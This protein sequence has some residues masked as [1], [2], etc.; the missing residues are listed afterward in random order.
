M[1]G[2]KYLSW[3]KSFYKVHLHR[4]GSYFF[5]APYKINFDMTYLCNSRCTNCGIWKIC[6]RD[7]ASVRRELSAAEYDQIFTKTASSLYFVSFEGGEPF[8]RKDAGNIFHSCLSRCKNLISLLIATNGSLPLR[9]EKIAKEILK[10]NSTSSLYFSISLD[11]FEETHNRL[12]GISNG[13]QLAVETYDR[14]CRIGNKRLI[15]FFQYT[16]C[17]SNWKEALSFYEKMPKSTVFTLYHC[18]PFFC[19]EDSP[20]GLMEMEERDEFLSVLNRLAKV[21]RVQ[22]P[23]DFLK[24]IYLYSALSYVRTRKNPLPCYA[25]FASLSADPYGDIRPCAF[26]PHFFGNL[27][28]S[29][30]ALAPLLFSEEARGIKNRLKKETCPL[31]WMNCDALPSMLHVFPKAI[32]DY[33][34]GRIS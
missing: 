30:Y 7:P 23:L 8:L 6:R 14:L 10:I 27:R 15:P 17:R 26:S 29:D 12:R 25:G 2:S 22:S 3:F 33:F 34:K 32:L 24:K 16:L 4:K 5:Q 11:G 18:L 28:N 21:Y 9:V 19:N 13:Y 1:Q 20:Q 31:C